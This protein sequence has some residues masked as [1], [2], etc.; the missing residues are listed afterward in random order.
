L[1]AGTLSA[2]SAAQSATDIRPDW[3]KIG[4]FA[5][6]LQLA[7]PVTGP[8]DAVWFS[9]EGDRLFARTRTGR[10]L[11][12]SDFEA[13]TGATS[14]AAIPDPGLTPPPIVLPEA[15]ASLQAAPSDP[16]SVYALGTHLYQS[17]DSGRT[18][19]NLTGYGD[20]SVIGSNQHGL[21]ISPRDPRQ[22]V[23]ANDFGVWR[24]LDGGLSWT[25]LNQK[26][27]NLPVRSI[28]STARSGKGVRILIDGIGAAGL[29][30]GGSVAR[31]NW[32]PAEDSNPQAESQSEAAARASVSQ[33]VGANITAT[34]SSGDIGYAGADDGRLWV[35]ADRG[36]TWTESPQRGGGA[37]ERIFIDPEAPRVALAAAAGTGT[38]LLRT[39]NTGLFWDDVTGNLPDV[40]VHGV[41]ADRSTGA[42]YVATDRGVFQ[43]RM[44]LNVPG[45][46]SPWTPITGSLPPAK[47][48]DVKLDPTGNQL[49]VA[50]DGY[51]VYA[52]AAPH[53]AKTFRLVNA[54]DLSQ[55]AA[56]PG[57]LL[58]VLGGKIQSARVAA[59]NFPVLSS[60]DA[61]S[62]IQVPFEIVFD[63]N[64]PQL[65]LSLEAASGRVNLGVP[66]KN[67]SPAIFV[68]RDGAPMLLDADTGLT[69]DAGNAARSRSR[70]QILATG[71]G[72]VKPNW[73]TGMPQPLENPPAVVANVQ[74][75][76]DRVPVEVTRAT[77][78]PGYV[79]LY[80]IELQLPALVNSGPAELSLSV[81]GQ[82]SNRV[83][84]ILEAG[85]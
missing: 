8:V 54:A 46:F 34:V 27:P 71:L 84:L 6:D 39:T 14:P 17:G 33:A 79:G 5:V 30:P 82:E 51:G 78:A 62:E 31:E 83:R 66:I 42:V 16:R 80:L 21:A 32:V 77:L 81:D 10:I 24:S 63:A 59:L 38:H 43:G 3:R 49:Y 26:L 37:I 56:A 12:T 61:S 1:L 72:K 47:A 68:D 70:I 25:G 35:S 57:G 20:R 67:V 55:R 53:R 29:R 15:R 4:G 73:P 13:W 58:S 36:A 48:F 9:P 22:I 44:D 45:A 41:A 69:L 85:N 28:L 76:V 23:V 60:S 2:Q 19:T 40:P 64:S 52:A 74:A 75:F 50:L 18:W 11:E 65:A 7:S